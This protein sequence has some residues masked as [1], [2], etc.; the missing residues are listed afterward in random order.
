MDRTGI[1]L[2]NVRILGSDIQIRG[3]C[4]QNAKLESLINFYAEFRPHHS[5]LS[6]YPRPHCPS[7][8]IW[9]SLHQQNLIFPCRQA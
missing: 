5:V 2:S 3:L 8:G 4:T 6:L 1:G 9:I 7:Q